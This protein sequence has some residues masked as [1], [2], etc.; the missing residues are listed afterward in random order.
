MV[1][2]GRGVLYI[3]RSRNFWCS[4]FQEFLV[5]LVPEIFGVVGS[6]NFWCT[7]LPLF[8]LI[9]LLLTSK[10]V[11]LASWYQLEVSY[12]ITLFF[13]DHLF[14]NLLVRRLVCHKAS[15]DVIKYLVIALVCPFASLWYF[16]LDVK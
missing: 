16:C 3:E 11:I 13:K 14:A 5:Y 8:L 15:D 4:L 6:R 2:G 12:A 10:A 9:F 7:W 1:V